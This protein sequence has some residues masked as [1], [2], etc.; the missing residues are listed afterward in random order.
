MS[1]SRPPFKVDWLPI[2]WANTPSAHTAGGPAYPGT[3]SG[4]AGYTAGARRRA[5]PAGDDGPRAGA[6][7]PLVAPRRPHFADD[8]GLLARAPRRLPPFGDHGPGEFV[9]HRW[10]PLWSRL[11]RCHEGGPRRCA[12]ADLALRQR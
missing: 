2:A 4:R 1:S 8:P 7:G 6:V 11:A 10:S 5:H 12:S 3:W 9:V